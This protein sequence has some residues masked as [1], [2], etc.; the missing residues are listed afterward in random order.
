MPDFI[1]FRTKRYDIVIFNATLSLPR[2]D[3]SAYQN[4]A[5]CLKGAILAF[6]ED[7]FSGSAGLNRHVAGNERVL[8]ERSQRL[9]LGPQ[10]CRRHREMPLEA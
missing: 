9:H 4:V 1:G 5:L 10:S 7:R 8:Q 3:K 6:R 2:P